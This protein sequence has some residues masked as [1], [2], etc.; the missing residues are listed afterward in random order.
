MSKLPGWLGRLGAELT[1]LGDRLEQRRDEA[2]GQG[3]GR[4]GLPG[5]G[6]AGPAGDVPASA[7]AAADVP[8][9]AVRVA[10]ERRGAAADHVPPPP[11]YAPSV[12]ARPDPVAAIPWGMRVAAEAGWRLLVLAGTLWV[13]MRVISAVQLVVLAFVAALLVTAM[14]QPTVARLRGY[15][16]PRGLATAVTAVL[17]FVIMGLVGWF[18]VWQVMDN[19]DTLSD[20]VRDGIEELKRW[21]LDSPFHVTEQQI[22]DIAKNLSDTIGTNTEQITSAGLEGVTVMVEVLTGILLAMFSTLFLLYDGRRIWHWVLKLVPA[23]ARPGVAG[24]GPRAWRTLT[25]YVRGTVIVALIDAIFIGLGI[26][27]LDVP[28]A[29]PLAVFIF[30]FAFIPLVGAVISGALAVVVALVTEGVFTALMVLAVVLAV[31][32]IEGHVLQPFI[33]GRAVRVHPLAVVLSVAAGGM[34]AGIGGAVV[35]VPLVAV[36]NTVVGYLRTYG[37]EQALRYAPS[38]RGATAIDVAPTP[39]PGSPPENSDRGD[40]ED[41]AGGGT[42]SGS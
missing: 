38:P 12:A 33:L 22:N 4:T 31:Q 7:V 29:V 28:M 14:L 16:L 24:A 30:L 6:D 11:S 35:A 19:I 10:D 27:F 8:A 26:F 25:A 36:T 41:G 39:A 20:K 9:G 34:I 15:G 2:A 40:D 37:Q 32:Q 5:A 13:L 18:V 42:K 17:G 23:Q 21:L 3:A 1:E